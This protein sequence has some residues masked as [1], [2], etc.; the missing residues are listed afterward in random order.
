MKYTTA[1]KKARQGE[2]QFIK[3]IKYGI[4]E[5]KYQTPTGKWKSKEIEI[6]ESMLR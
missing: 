2:F 3:D 4:N 1:V 6:V 5:V